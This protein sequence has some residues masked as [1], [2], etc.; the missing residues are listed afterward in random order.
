VELFN[1]LYL[2]I[3]VELRYFC[4]I[5]SIQVFTVVLCHY[6]DC[7]QNFNNVIQKEGILQ[8]NYIGLDCIILHGTKHNVI[9]KSIHLIKYSYRLEQNYV[10]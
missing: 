3:L 7:A 10:N 1:G 6:S 8:I 5:R 4:S 9:L 2:V